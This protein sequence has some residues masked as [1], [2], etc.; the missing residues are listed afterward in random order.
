MK[1][2]AKGLI[3][4]GALVVVALVGYAALRIVA[5]RRDG[6]SYVT[7]PVSY[8]D[9]SS[10]VSETGTVNPVNEV[11]VGSEVSGT[12]TALYADY[13]SV[14]RQ[15]E[16]LAKLDPTNFQAA[17][18]SAAASLRLAKANL[19]NA[20]NNAQKS[21]AQRDLSELTLQRD[22]ELAK[23][24]LIAQ[25]Q[26]DT[27]RMAAL[28]SSLDYQS[29]L[30]A[31]E[32]AQTQVSVA[33]A[34]LQQA[35]YNLQRTIVTSPIDGVVL[36]RSVSVGQAVAASLQAPVLFV[37]ASSL[38]DM[39]VDTAVD[40]ADVG[41]VKSGQAARI[42]VTAFPNVAFNGTIKEVRVDPTTVQNVVTYDAVV[43]VHDTTGRLLPGMTAQVTIETGSRTHVLSVPIAAL[44]YRPSST[45][46]NGASTSR[47][48]GAFGS[49]G[50]F[51]GL[52][53]GRNGGST[54]G[55]LPVAG[56]PGSRAL[57][58]VL[59]NG[60][61]APVQITIGLSDD[62]NVEIASNELSASEQVI[63]AERTGASARRPTG[64]APAGTQ[65]SP[66]RPT[67]AQ[68]R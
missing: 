57:I 13:N 16:I 15:G 1:R 32:V 54:G 66:G 58:W 24:S 28:A 2:A 23:Q 20:R 7:R 50:G 52:R 55:E 8:A 64:T 51:G 37:L 3:V 35:Q 19:D 60:R 22:Q 18:D 26:I 30:G 65:P 63:V 11:Q 43:S 10:S 39:Q 47:G 5:A 62:R 34:Q 29:S 68:V 49:V 59:R 44:L 41:S 21:K 27:D 38:S 46:A 42:T 12:I 45:R 40:E 6:V 4:F 67:G 56:A 48:A 53:G 17:V 25:S 9:I 14:V 61:P 36:A 31:I 33:Q